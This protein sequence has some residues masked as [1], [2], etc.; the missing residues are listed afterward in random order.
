MLIQMQQM[1]QMKNPSS[2]LSKKMTSVRLFGSI[3]IA[4][5]FF[6]ACSKSSDKPTSKPNSLTQQEEATQSSESTQT[7]QMSKGENPDLKNGEQNSDPNHPVDPDTVNWNSLVV[8][9]VNL[10]PSRV[11]SQGLTVSVIDQKSGVKIFS[12]Y[13]SC[14]LCVDVHAVNFSPNGKYLTVSF[15]KNYIRDWEMTTIIYNLS[16]PDPSNPKF[17]GEVVFETSAQSLAFDPKG[18]FVILSD[19]VS[20]KQYLLSDQSLM[21]EHKLSEVHQ[22]AALKKTAG[23]FVSPNSN[24]AVVVRLISVG[25]ISTSRI[26]FVDL[27]EP[28]KSYVISSSGTLVDES[29]LLEPDFKTHFVSNE[30]ITFKRGYSEP[31]QIIYLDKKSVTKLH[32][33]SMAVYEKN[34]YYVEKIT[35][36][37]K[38][39]VLKRL[40]LTTGVDE[41]I[42]DPGEQRGY[43]EIRISQDKKNLF[44]FNSEK[45]E[46]YDLKT[47]QSTVL[48]SEIKN[49]GNWQFLQRGEKEFI[50]FESIVESF[51]Y[52]VHEDQVVFRV[53]PNEKNIVKIAL[54]PTADLVMLTAQMKHPLTRTSSVFKLDYL[55]NLKS[56][57]L[58]RLVD[59]RKIRDPITNNYRTLWTHKN[60][61]YAGSTYHL[62]S[63]D[64]IKLGHTGYIIDSQINYDHT[65]LVSASLDKTAKIY[66]LRTKAIVASLDI[67]ENPRFVTLSADSKLLAVMLRNDE[68]LIYD[69]D[70]RTVIHRIT[71]IGQYYEFP[72]TSSGYYTGDAT[73]FFQFTA[74]SKFLYA[75]NV[76]YEVQSMQQVGF[77]FHDEYYHTPTISNYFT[78]TGNGVVIFYGNRNKDLSALYRMSK[79]KFFW[80]KE[81]NGHLH[82]SH[83]RK[84]FR[85]ETFFVMPRI[86]G[87]EIDD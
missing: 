8:S 66:D 24:L 34:I 31:L 26:D 72:D 21:S 68:I 59:P 73:R 2:V 11:Y 82:F 4:I 17:L 47:L 64:E 18:E 50:V 56:F 19:G 62:E 39:Y 58:N 49:N 7:S 33:E 38:R 45:L 63:S 69:V 27:K 41:Q 61:L 28:E 84:N 46:I 48:K 3:L 60:K 57:S 13:I 6:G 77:A 80:E 14:G 87:P 9:S 54:N 12:Q 20:L 42:L 75:Y 1:K 15:A 22:L 70:S 36:S 30:I 86:L 40:D 79:D 85:S 43:F 76:I 71:H 16:K 83:K 52:D 32:T 29:A 44:L 51:L 55:A 67:P 74:D 81:T 53:L 78:P 37:G 23:M 35:N 65:K 10:Y 25:N 5:I